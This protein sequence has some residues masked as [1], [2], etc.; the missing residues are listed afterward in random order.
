MAPKERTS[1]DAQFSEFELVFPSYS[2]S[3]LADLFGFIEVR[4]QITEHLTVRLP[5]G[6][7][8]S[9]QIL[10]GEKNIATSKKRDNLTM[11]AC[12]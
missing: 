1:G 4:M 11:P 5:L 10:R 8:E 6:V 7:E 3:N 9:N 12:C 2:S